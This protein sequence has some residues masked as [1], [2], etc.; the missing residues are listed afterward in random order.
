MIAVRNAVRRLRSAV[1]GILRRKRLEG[2]PV[3][4][5]GIRIGTRTIDGAL[6]FGPNVKVQPIFTQASGEQHAKYTDDAK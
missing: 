1:Q 4:V 6:V 2:D 5:G 3:V